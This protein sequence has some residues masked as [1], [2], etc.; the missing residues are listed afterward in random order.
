[1]HAVQVGKVLSVTEG[2]GRFLEISFIKFQTWLRR[3][4][5]STILNELSEWEGLLREKLPGSVDDI[6]DVLMPQT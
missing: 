1:M 5:R 2:R 4:D 3:P 6:D